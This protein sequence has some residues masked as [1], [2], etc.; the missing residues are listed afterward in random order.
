MCSAEIEQ[1]DREGFVVLENF[2]GPDFLRALRIRADE[3]LEQEGEAAGSE[4]KQEPDARRL[5]N[6]V[7]KGEVFERA[8]LVPR[9][10]ALAEHVLGP[11]FKLGSVNFRSANPH[12]SSSQPLHVDVGALPDEKG[13]SVCNTIWMLDDFTPENGATRCVP[14]THRSG[15]RPQEVLEDPSVPHPNEILVT[16]KAGTVVVMNA[17]M[18]HG[19]TANH[20]GFPRR[21]LHVFYTRW[22]KPQQQYQKKLLRPE[23]QAK[24]SPDLRRILALDD[25]LNDKLCQE[26]TSMSGFMR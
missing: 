12:S 13:F 25:P 26:T 7:D 3:L 23:V 11:R 18:W 15:K 21:A 19:G 24:L 8:V 22:D 16:G 6:L 10:L 14:G 9:I 1:L 20:T 17:H 5:A 2:I 4:F